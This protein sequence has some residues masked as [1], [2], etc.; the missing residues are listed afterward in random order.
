MSLP[1]RKVDPQIRL[2]KVLDTYAQLCKESESKNWHDFI[3]NKF[4]SSEIWRFFI[5]GIR[6]N[7]GQKLIDYYANQEVLLRTCSKSFN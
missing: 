6:Q 1:E 4:P 3:K 2:S 5:D 7:D